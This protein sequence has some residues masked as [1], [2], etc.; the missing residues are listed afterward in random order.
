MGRQRGDQ[1]TVIVHHRNP[2][3]TE[4]TSCAIRIKRV[5][6]GQ[7]LSLAVSENSSDPVT[8]KNC[9]WLIAHRK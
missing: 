8:C 2:N 7:L 3:Q 9:Q 6:G 1:R 4:L 5:V